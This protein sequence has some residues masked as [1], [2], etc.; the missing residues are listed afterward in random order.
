MSFDFV[1]F[2]HS[3]LNHNVQAHGHAAESQRRPGKLRRKEVEGIKAACL[4]C[5]LCSNASW[6]QTVWQASGI[7]PGFFFL[8]LLLC[9]GQRV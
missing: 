1:N 8:S 6:Q 2:T 7:S 9:A 5:A 4:G 3:H